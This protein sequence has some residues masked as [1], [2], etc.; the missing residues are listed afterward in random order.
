MA[1]GIVL[2]PYGK[3]GGGYPPAA[4]DYTYK[5]A[6]SWY[7]S[8]AANERPFNTPGVYD[9]RLDP[10]HSRRGEEG[11]Y[12]DTPLGNG[13]PSWWS[14]LKAKFAGRSLGAIPTDF[15]LAT[16]YQY[17]PVY[18]GWVKTQQGYA[19]GPWLPPHGNPSWA[20]YPTPVAPLVG[21]AQATQPYRNGGLSP[22]L[23]G[24]RDSN[25]VVPPTSTV[26]DVLGVMT[27]HNDRALAL[28]IVSTTAVTVSALLGVFRTLKLIKDEK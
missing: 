21:Y 3:V 22:N 19:T 20:G 23:A 4:I 17:L 28:A 2:S 7:G 12:Y 26:D 14:R 15:E 11:Y 6:T 8:I 1:F 10:Q 27:A 16:R 24:L 9:P 5:G 25:P 13:R 18:S